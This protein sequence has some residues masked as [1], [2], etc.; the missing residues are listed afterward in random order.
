MNAGLINIHHND[1]EN[2]IEDPEF[3]FN[4]AASSYVNTSETTPK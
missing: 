3:F 1:P 2:F 4:I